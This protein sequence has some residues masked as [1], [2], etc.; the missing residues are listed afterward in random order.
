MNLVPNFTAGHNSQSGRFLRTRELRVG[1]VVVVRSGWGWGWGWGIGWWPG[2][3]Q[4]TNHYRYPSI[5]RHQSILFSWLARLTIIIQSSPP[6]NTP[7]QHTKRPDWLLWHA[8]KFDI[9]LIGSAA[10]S[11]NIWSKQMCCMCTS[12]CKNDYM[13][14]DTCI[15][16]CVYS[17]DIHAG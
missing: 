9:R 14:M 6:P 13:N 2:N 3:D 8:L 11:C 15:L 10:D 7:P 17:Q 4:E 1:V 12:L 5:Y 16:R